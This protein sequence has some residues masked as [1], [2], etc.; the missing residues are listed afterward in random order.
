[1]ASLT[2]TIVI[3][4]ND[5]LG[6]L[7]WLALPQLD[8]EQPRTLSGN[9]GMLD[10]IRALNWVR[11]NVAGFGGDAG[12]VTI[13]GQ[14]AGASAVCTMLASPL[15]AGLFARAIVESIGCNQ[16]PNS[17]QA[18]EQTSQR[19]AAAVGC[20]DAATMLTCLRSAW[21]PN[22]IAAEQKVVVRAPTY[23]TPVLPAP[24]EDA[25]ASDKWN[26]V[27]V[28]IGNVRSEGKLFVFINPT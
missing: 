20:A 15:A 25:I 5:R 18:A 12:R 16:G 22:L 27:P 1:M 26:K 28:L 3:S 10:Q 24:R 13:A 14:S 4:I 2:Q 8:K 21:A 17:L 7:G 6:A 19:S 11:A 9:Y 23:G